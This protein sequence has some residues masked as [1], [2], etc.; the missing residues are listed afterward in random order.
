MGRR[1]GPA[2]AAARGRWRRAVP[3]AASLSAALEPGRQ[4]LHSSGA[5]HPDTLRTS[6]RIPATTTRATYG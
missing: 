5:L 6:H 2:A 3:R 1:R 4:H